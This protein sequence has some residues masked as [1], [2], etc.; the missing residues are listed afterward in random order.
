MSAPPKARVDEDED[1][2]DL[3]DV[4]EQFSAA[5]TKSRT[6]VTAPAASSS[7]TSPPAPYSA[8]K[9]ASAQPQPGL[10]GLDLSEDFAREL[11]LGMESLMREIAGDAG[12]DADA[13]KGLGGAGVQT[14]EEKQQEEAFKAAWEKM[15][16]ESM[17]GALEPDDL[18]AGAAS[19]GEG[20]ESGG[21]PGATDAAG[22]T[23]A[24]QAS[25]KKAMEKL[26]ESDSNMQTDAQ[27]PIEALMAQLTD[28]LGDLSGESDEDLQ[29]FLE[30]MMSQLMSKEVLYE[31]LKEL[32]TKFPEYL[33]DS[34]ATLSADD[35]KRYEAQYAL[36]EQIVAIFDDP[37]YSDD[38][39]QKSSQVVALVTEMQSHGS[40]PPDIMGSLPPGLEFGAD[41]SPKLPEGC[42]I[43]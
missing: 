32:H 28:G 14:E 12:L 16:V 33:K 21:Q 22:E 26:K 17:N 5:P 20:R 19:K 41:G 37:A 34:A 10:L 38:D 23:D 36:S 30:G 24:F 35:K 8:S 15:L 7:V 43:T 31:P 18:L 27:D 42:T 2:D 13:T 25:I 11:T 40:P 3:D 4:L 9:P 6:P 29:K 39:P 1:L